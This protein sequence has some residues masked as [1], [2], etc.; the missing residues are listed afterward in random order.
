MRR[1]RELSV[2]VFLIPYYAAFVKLGEIKAFK[3]FVELRHPKSDGESSVE[4]LTYANQ[5]INI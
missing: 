4:M 5:F 2:A 3:F 1:S